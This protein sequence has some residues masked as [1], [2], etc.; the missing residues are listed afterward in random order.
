[1]CEI[2]SAP[3]SC[4]GAACSEYSHG[5]AKMNGFATY[6]LFFAIFAGFNGLLMFVEPSWWLNHTFDF[7]DE[8][9]TEITKLFARSYGAVLLAICL[10]IPSMKPEKFCRLT[11][12]VTFL[13]F[14]LYAEAAYNG[15][16]GTNQGAFTIQAG[17]QFV[18]LVTNVIVLYA[19]T[20]AEQQMHSSAHYHPQYTDRRC[21]LM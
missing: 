9:L 7:V 6:S 4:I 18:L 5:C 15:V 12:L 20:P 2:L 21:L 8:P 1:M 19:S 13:L 11:L 10:S 14:L 3:C 16:E 17:I